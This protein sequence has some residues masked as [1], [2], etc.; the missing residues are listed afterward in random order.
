[1]LFWDDAQSLALRF[2]PERSERLRWQES[3]EDPDAFSLGLGPDLYVLPALQTLYVDLTTRT[4][5][6][7]EVGVASHLVERMVSGPPVPETM[8]A[9]AEESLRSLGCLEVTESAAAKAAPPVARLKPRL[10]IGLETGSRFG[11]MLDI[12]WEAV[13]GDDVFPL[14][15]WAPVRE[16]NKVAHVVRNMSEEGRLSGE[17]E[18]F[19]E[20]KLHDFANAQGKK[21]VAEAAQVLATQVIPELV[22]KGW[23]CEVSD[24]FPA[25]MPILD[26]E[27]AEELRPVSEGHAWFELGLNVVIAGKSVPLL[28][29]LL[30]AIRSG[31]IQLNEDPRAKDFPL[32][33]NLK[34]P[35]GSVV[36]V[37][38]ARLQRWL[39]PLIELR[40]R[41]L[42]KED[43]LIVPGVTAVELAEAL[44]GPFSDSKRLAAL[45][46]RL[47]SLVDLK[48]E[49]EGEGFSGQLRAYQREGLAWLGFLHEGGLG[50]VFADD[51]GLGKT[52]QLLAFFQ[53]LQTKGAL[54]KGAPILVVAPR[55]VVGLSLIHISEP[56][57]PSKSSRMPSSA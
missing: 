57:R 38:H 49:L 31:D 20:L 35:D 27:W 17:L 33:T 41:G 52:V 19:S 54:P 2:G 21:E 12:A 9:V 46:E 7:L 50:G 47:A 39:R 56:T 30:Q 8:L 3:E 5:G 53:S 34:L 42:D 11:D 40:L 29:M 16:G 24:D 18:A 28:P 43:K 22:A 26:V 15:E 55:S 10:R 48:P 4:I 13:Y 14:G 37:G 32:G 44:P 51:M 23:L 6:P 45:R 1:M 36:H 25:Q